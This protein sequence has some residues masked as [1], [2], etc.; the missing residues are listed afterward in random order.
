MFLWSMKNFKLNDCEASYKPWAAFTK[1][2]IQSRISLLSAHKAILEGLTSNPIRLS[3]NF[4]MKLVILVWNFDF[5][6]VT[7]A[8]LIN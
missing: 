8:V 2:K 7:K 3:R 4:G 6:P 5:I 1:S